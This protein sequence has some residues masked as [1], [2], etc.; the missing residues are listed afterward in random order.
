MI[1]DLF[2]SGFVRG[3]ANSNLNFCLNISNLLLKYLIINTLFGA[4][5]QVP[6]EDLQVA[7]RLLI[8]ALH[9]RENYMQMSYQTFPSITARFLR[10]VAGAAGTQASDD[11]QHEDRKTIQGTKSF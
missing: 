4:F 1:L 6:L 5:F 7:S 11:V 9:I 2:S 10:Q 8:Q 3:P